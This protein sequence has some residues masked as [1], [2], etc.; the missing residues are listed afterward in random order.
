[1]D[2]KSFHCIFCKEVSTYIIGQPEEYTEHLQLVHNVTQDFNSVFAINFL[3]KSEK[4]D[5]I[6][7]AK[8]ITKR[9][10]IFYCAICSN[11]TEFMIGN[12]K[13]FK[14]HLTFFHHIFYEFGTLLSINLLGEN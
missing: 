6:E 9:G 2:S 7:K 4:S 13:Y 3:D 11:S 8:K 10:D 1:M 12:F 5:L 14:D